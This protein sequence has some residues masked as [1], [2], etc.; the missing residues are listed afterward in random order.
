MNFINDDDL[1]LRRCGEKTDFL[2]QFPD[3][4]D[5][6]IGGTINLI[7]V[8]GR[9][10]RDLN[11]RW[12]FITRVGI[13]SLLTVNGLCHDAGQGGFPHTTDTGKQNGM[14]NPVPDKTILQCFDHRHL[15][16]NLIEILGARFS[17]KNQIGH[18]K[19]LPRDC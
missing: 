13:R 2:L 12:T 16:D 5:A 17:G 18:K 4:L 19:G 11:T 6:A 7:E 9:A 15:A 10:C 8:K 1:V 14:G 3:L